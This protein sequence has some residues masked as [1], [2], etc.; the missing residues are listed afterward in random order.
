MT[1]PKAQ[2]L[3]VLHQQGIVAVLR[4]DSAAVVPNVVA[5]LL[6]GGIRAIEITMTTPNA[7]D[8]IGRIATQFADRDVL[9]GAGT[10]VTTR[11]AAAACDAGAQYIVAPTLSLDVIQ[12]CNQREVVVVPGAFTPSEIQYAWQ[13]GADIVKVFPANIGGPGYLR[14]LLGPLPGI[15]LIPSGGVD[16]ETAPQYFQAGA[17]AVAVGSVVIGRD[18]TRDNAMADIRVNAERFV[19]LVALARKQ[20]SSH[21]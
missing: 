3:E 16:F 10:V 21:R 5:A 12:Y 11:Q 4:C 18:P 8:L 2:V 1:D 17:F 14:D 13:S 6:D 7:I 20:G 9:V 15:R 19:S